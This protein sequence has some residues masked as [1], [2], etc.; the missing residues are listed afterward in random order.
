[1]KTNFVDKLEVGG[2]QG[3]GEKS[4]KSDFS[5]VTNCR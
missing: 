1:M 5:F 2:V 3:A 4:L